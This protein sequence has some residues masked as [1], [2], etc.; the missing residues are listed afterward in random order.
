[1]GCIV[2]DTTV[3]RQANAFYCDYEGCGERNQ[4]QPSG[5][6]P[7]GWKIIDLFQEGPIRSRDDVVIC[8]C[9]NHTQ[10]RV[11]IKVEPL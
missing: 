4:P 2:E 10:A 1:M 3:I 6:R 7:T 8:L 11:S 9:P 5:P